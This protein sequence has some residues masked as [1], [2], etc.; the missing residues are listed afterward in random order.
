M[1]LGRSLPFRTF[2]KVRAVQP[3]AIVDNK[4]LSAVLAMVKARQAEYAPKRQR[5]HAARQRPPNNLEAPGLPSKGR[6]SR[7]ALA[8]AVT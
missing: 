5:G 2:D 1:Q 3:G 8:A 6:A 7:A 4:R